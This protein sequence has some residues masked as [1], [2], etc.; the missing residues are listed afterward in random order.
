VQFSLG[1][2]PLEAQHEAVV[3]AAGMVDA[4]GVGDQRVG[5]RA[6]IQ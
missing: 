2:G 4:V 3:I 6:Q 1:E 5:Q